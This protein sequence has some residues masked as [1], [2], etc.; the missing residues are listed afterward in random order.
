MSSEEKIL[1]NEEP[2]LISRWFVA[3]I[4]NAFE[5]LGIEASEENLLKATEEVKAY[6]SG[7]LVPSGNEILEIMMSNLFDEK[8][9]D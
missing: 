6:F 5:R 1:T 2:I 9:V 8:T 7:V 3:D 4:E